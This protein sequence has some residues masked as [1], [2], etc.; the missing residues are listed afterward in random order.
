[1]KRFVK[2]KRGQV[3]VIE[4]FFASVLLLSALALIPTAQKTDE[5]SAVRLSATALNMLLSLDV[6]GRLAKLVDSREWTTLRSLIQSVVPAAM[7]FNL[8]VFNVNMTPLNDVLIS[9]G[10]PVSNNM[11]SANYVCASTSENYAVYFLR[12]QLSAVE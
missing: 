9:N 7:W 2:N 6:D 11:Q 8:T 1:M 4:A 3:R 10:G 12:L 5:S